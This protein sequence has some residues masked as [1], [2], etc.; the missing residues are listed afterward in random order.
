MNKFSVI[1]LAWR[2]AKP[3]SERLNAPIYVEELTE[4]RFKKLGAGAVVLDHDGVLGPSRS[5][6]PDETGIEILNNAVKAFG[7]GKVFILS[8]TSS[9]R[10]IRELEY[11]NLVDG[12]RYIKSEKKPDPAGL[13]IASD[14]SRIDIRKIAVIDDGP[15]TGILMA[16]SSGAI[17]VYVKRKRM[18]ENLLAKA[19]RLSTTWPQIALVRFLNLLRK[20]WS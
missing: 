16:L 7:A 5:D 4:E 20:V 19:V 9:K 12:A 6:A 2:L 17:P 10:E 14:L 11:E 3:L 15:L 13:D 18:S 8:N 1:P